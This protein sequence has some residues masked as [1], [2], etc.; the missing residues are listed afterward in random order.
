[1]TKRKILIVGAGTVG[2]ATGLGLIK[3]G[4]DVTFYDINPAQ[5][6]VIKNQ[7]HATTTNLLNQP[8]FEIA[9]I[10]V[11][12]ELN[13]SNQF[14]LQPLRTAI[15][16]IAQHAEFT[17]SKNIIGISSTLFP[18]SA[19]M[20]YQELQLHNP[21][22]ASFV[23]IA[24]LPEF[25]R[26]RSSESDFLSGPVR[27]VGSPIKETRAIFKELLQSTC[28]HFIEFSTF[29]EAELMKLTHNLANATEITFWNQ[30]KLL[31][32]HYSVDTLSI[33]SA[34]QLSAESRYNPNYSYASGEAIAGQCLPKDLKAA[35]GGME[36]IG[37]DTSHL[38]GTLKF[39]FPELYN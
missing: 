7:G 16:S 4:H 21:V 18:G 10:C 20:L 32:E 11:Q 3:L 12:T 35:Q 25:I 22:S 8:A 13:D 14:D 33:K 29:E 26:E 30:I 39:N 1:M 37:L 23:E 31:A 36:S 38:R 17:G 34:V 9:L 2:R 24:L 15:E 5:L 27:V 28:N 19:T 6:E